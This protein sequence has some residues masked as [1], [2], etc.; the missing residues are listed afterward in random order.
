MQA[1]DPSIF[2]NDFKKKLDFKHSSGGKWS[3]NESRI[4]KQMN[5]L[6]GNGKSSFEEMFNPLEG[7][8]SNELLVENRWENFLSYVEKR[9]K[10][11]KKFE[12]NEE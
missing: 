6:E 3:L 1:S 4:K 11:S 9:E 10:K 2:A 7:N 5:L 8:R 12:G